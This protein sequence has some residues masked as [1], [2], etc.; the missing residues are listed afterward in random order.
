MRSRGTGLK[1][2][3]KLVLTICY[4]YVLSLFDHADLIL[5]LPSAVAK[6]DVLFLAMYISGM[7]L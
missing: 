1:E 7:C 4:K 2:N 5:I 3:S 6:Q